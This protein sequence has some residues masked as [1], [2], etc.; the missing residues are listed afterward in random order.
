MDDGNAQVGW[1]EAQWNRVREEVLRAWQSVRVAGS[2]LPVYGALP[3][4]TQVV[5]SEVFDVDGTVDERS[6]APLIEISL[7]VSLSRQQVLE[8]DLDSALLLFRR[9]AVQVGQLEDWFIFNGTYDYEGKLFPET[10]SPTVQVNVQLPLE[11]Y[12]PAYRFLDPLIGG[13]PARSGPQTPIAGREVQLRGLRQRNPGAL[14]L[15]GGSRTLVPP[16]VSGGRTWSLAPVE[17]KNLAPDGLITGVVDAMSTLEGNGY[18]APYVCVFGREPFEKAH[19]PTGNAVAFP[20][21]RLEPLIGRQLLHSSSLDMPPAT[22]HPYDP[23]TAE[24]WQKRGVLLSLSGESVDLA[25][26]APATPEFRQVD[27]NGRYLFSVS[28]RF[29]L[30]IKD[31]LAVVPLRF[32]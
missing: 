10:V 31:P 9:R 18:V 12:R 13:A 7:P 32:R 2:F 4:A 25:I 1:S 27:A 19:S 30:R 23:P 28:E 15:M 16:Q 29:A 8:E 6:V 21:D 22:F 5:P 17:A 20:R 3:R 26:A 24:A 11:S 14:G